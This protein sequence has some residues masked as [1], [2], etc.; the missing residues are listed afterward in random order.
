MGTLWRRSVMVIDRRGCNSHGAFVRVGELPCGL[1]PQNIQVSCEVRAV[2]GE[3]PPSMP[4]DEQCLG[5]LSCE[6]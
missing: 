4:H 2:L 6:L 3:T 1:L 5:E